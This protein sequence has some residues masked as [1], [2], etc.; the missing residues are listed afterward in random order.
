MKKIILLIVVVLTYVKIGNAQST[1]PVKSNGVDIILTVWSAGENP[2]ETVLVVPGWG[3]GP[4]DVLGIGKALSSEGIPVVV[5]CPRGWHDSKG[6]ASFAHGLADIG[7]ALK[8]I[9]NTKRTDLQ[10]TNIILGGH[11]WGG[12]MSLAYAA[13]D[14]TISRVFSVA[15]T[16]HG[17]LIRNYQ[18]D[19]TLAGIV[20]RILASTVAPAGP[21]RFDVESSLTELKQ[22]QDVYGIIENAR[23]LADRSILIFGGW[24]DVNTTI[25]DFL[26]PNYR[27]LKA[28]G[29]KDIT[30][31][32][33][34]DNHGFGSVRKEFYSDLISWIKK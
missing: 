13:Q 26:L 17:I 29:A 32:T 16:D 8:W 19:S 2:S 12:G 20:N 5:L 21:I 10:T 15:G 7:M 33:Y 23:N 24:E 18:S 1:I 4:S 28:A 27:A 6:I 11:S 25:D 3:G 34:H 31:K 22:N 14:T 9:R 30:F